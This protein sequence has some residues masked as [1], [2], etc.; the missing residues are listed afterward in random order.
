MT[1]TRIYR[2]LINTR[3][4]MDELIFI[5]DNK[6]S[7]FEVSQYK[8]QLQELDKLL[9]DVKNL[10][11][12]ITDFFKK[13]VEPTLDYYEFPCF[14]ELSNDVQKSYKLSSVPKY[15][16]EQPDMDKT[17]ETIKLTK[18]W[19]MFSTW[20]LLAYMCQKGALPECELV[21]NISW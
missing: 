7:V 11:R 18:K 2:T 1:K 5:A 14:E 13:E 17:I 20:R 16:W 6:L 21:V 19:P 4:K 12:L 8:I 15:D 10:E 3:R 9:E